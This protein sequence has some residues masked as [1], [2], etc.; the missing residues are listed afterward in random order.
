MLEDYLEKVL[1]QTNA[2]IDKST[3]N[4][5]IDIEKNETK[6]DDKEDAVEGEGTTAVNATG[7]VNSCF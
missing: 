4:T 6:L 2:H 1:E 3:G 7:L 5:S